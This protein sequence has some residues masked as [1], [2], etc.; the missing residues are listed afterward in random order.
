MFKSTRRL[1][2]KQQNRC[3]A[4]VLL[5]FISSAG[6]AEPDVLSRCTAIPDQAER[7]SCYDKAAAEQKVAEAGENSAK[8]ACG[9]GYTALARLWNTRP[10]CD[11]KLY[12]FLPYKQNY[13]IA[14]Y[15]GN[16]NNEPVSAKFGPARDQQLDN[17]ELKFQVSLKVKVAEQ[18]GGLADLWFGYTQQSNWQAFNGTNA[19]PFRQS[20]YEPE[21]VLGFPLHTEASM[22]G[23]TPRM[24]NFGLD[25]QSSGQSDP[26]ERSWNRAYVQFGVDRD[27]DQNPDRFALLVRAWYRIPEGKAEDD[28]PDIVHY[29]GYG[30]VL[31][32]WRHGDSNLSALVRNNLQQQNNRGSVQ[33]DWSIPITRRPSLG[34]VDVA[35]QNGRELR[36]YVQLFTGY[37]ETLIDYNHYQTTIGIGLMLSD[38]L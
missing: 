25:H 19:R 12:Q 31:F 27:I 7:L 18:M 14:R 13:L 20:N 38:W 3:L 11:S 9:A 10:N 23:L 5:L 26:F 4:A 24:I 36:F 8:Q 28:N 35:R 33:L 34:N 37:G 2:R 30:D 16:P 6:A 1:F 21:L 32:F 17:T 15:S 22:L 29:L